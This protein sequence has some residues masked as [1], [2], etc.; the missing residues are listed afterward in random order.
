[1]KFIKVTHYV[2]VS[3]DGKPSFIILMDGKVFISIDIEFI[4]DTPENREYLIDVY[5]CE[6]YLDELDNSCIDNHDSITTANYMMF[7]CEEVTEFEFIAPNLENANYMLDEC[8][9]LTNLKLVAPNLKYARYMARG[10]KK[11]TNL[12]L[13]APKLENADYMIYRCDNIENFE[14]VVPQYIMK[15]YQHLFNKG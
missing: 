14:L 8:E 2:P 11:L 1:M 13:V 3:Y 7:G 5:G 4:E 9:K 12:K 15:Q 10:C 6:E